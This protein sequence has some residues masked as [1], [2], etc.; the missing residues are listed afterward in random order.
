MSRLEP[1]RRSD[2]IDKLTWL[3]LAED[4]AALSRSLEQLMALPRPVKVKRASLMSL[5]AKFMSAALCV[6]AFVNMK[7][8]VGFFRP[9]LGGGCRGMSLP[10]VAA[11]YS[12]EATTLHGQ[13]KARFPESR[14]GFN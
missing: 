9:V 5:A 12:L 13:W 1:K 10:S 11:L 4:H 14:V 8:D 3:A 2:R 6:R 7:M